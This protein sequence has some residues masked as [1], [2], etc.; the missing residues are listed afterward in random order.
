MYRFRGLGV[1][2]NRVLFL[3]ILFRPRRSRW[4]QMKHE[5]E[6]GGLQGCATVN[7]SQIIHGHGS[8]LGKLLRTIVALLNYQ[9]DPYVHP[10]WSLGKTNISSSSY[11][12][13]GFTC[14]SR[15]GSFS[16]LEDTTRECSCHL[17]PCSRHLPPSAANLK[18][19]KTSKN[20]NNRIWSK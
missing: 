1:K 8:L 16:G 10:S 7:I 13:L 14:W 20:C 4:T 2:G 19:N 6:P 12:G 11:T 17:P 15:V 9:R 5:M 3:P 18:N